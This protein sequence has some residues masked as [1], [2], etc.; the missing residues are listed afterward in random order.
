M[1]HWVLFFIRN[2]HLYYFDSFGMNPEIYKGDI[3]MFFKSFQG[4]KTIVFNKPIQNDFSYVCGAYTIIL[5]YFMTKNNSINLIKSKFTK[6]TCRN[7]NFIVKKLYSVA[8]ISLT[9][10][11]LLCPNEMSHINCKHY[12]EC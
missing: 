7:D 8:G 5:A 12:C 2:Y 1:G 11:Q 10:N 4:F 6:N 3:S 9:C